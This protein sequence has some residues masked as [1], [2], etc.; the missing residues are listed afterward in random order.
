[1]SDVGQLTAV[2]APMLI[3]LL[4]G[5]GWL[6]RHERERREAVESQLSEK[7]YT[8]Y[9]TLLDIFFDVLKAGKIPPADLKTAYD[10]C[11]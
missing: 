9:T 3:V 2:L 10:G 8:C 5:S 6:I 1:M 4:A 7:K 11:E